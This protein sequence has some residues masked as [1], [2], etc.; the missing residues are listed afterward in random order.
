MGE[1]AQRSNRVCERRDFS[2]N[3]I[4]GCEFGSQQN[5]ALSHLAKI[6]E[7]LAALE[8]AIS[9]PEATDIIVEARKSIYSTR[10]IVSNAE[11]RFVTL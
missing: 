11:S 7:R 4:S 1:N 3:D 2:L 8:G 5:L 10:S 6:E 9:T